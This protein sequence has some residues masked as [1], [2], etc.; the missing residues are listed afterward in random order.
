MQEETE[1][2]FQDAESQFVYVVPPSGYESDSSA[3]LPPVATGFNS[4]HMAPPSQHRDA[5]H[6]PR[7][8]HSSSTATLQ[9]RCPTGNHKTPDSSVQHDVTV[10]NASQVHNP[11]G[12]NTSVHR[13]VAG[14]S[15]DAG[16]DRASSTSTTQRNNAGSMHSTGGSL[17]NPGELLQGGQRAPSGRSADLQGK[18]EMQLPTRAAENAQGISVA[19]NFTYS[20]HSSHRCDETAPGPVAE[21][22][23]QGI[24]SCSHASGCH[25]H[26]IN[27]A[28]QDSW[29][30]CLFRSAIRSIGREEEHACAAESAA[31]VGTVVH[32]YHE[33]S[34]EGVA[35]LSLSMA[36]GGTLRRNASM[37]STARQPG[38]REVSDS[39]ISISNTL[40][41]DSL[42]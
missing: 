19:D 7:E 2:F 15:T 42:L 29:E 11:D 23:V 16:L 33:Q 21:G 8:V 35:T 38:Y 4:N 24:R 20:S 40:N 27:H 10:P 22:L 30:S 6:D 34:G 26:R 41:Q 36:S 3:S 25:S 5:M 9:S 1:A 31:A 37:D 12:S 32:A 17:L 28:R 18:E 13:T 14:L 39:K